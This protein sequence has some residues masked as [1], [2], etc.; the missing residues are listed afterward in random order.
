MYGHLLLIWL[1]IEGT[2][3]TINNLAYY[4]FDSSIEILTLSELGFKSLSKVF[5]NNFSTSYR[6]SGCSEIFISLDFLLLFA[7][8]K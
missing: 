7:F 2:V 5:L 3:F 6:G 8:D 4:S 1:R